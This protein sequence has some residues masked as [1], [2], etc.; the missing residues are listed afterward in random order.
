[1]ICDEKKSRNGDRGLVDDESKSLFYFVLENV[2]VYY[3]EMLVLIYHSAS[4]VM[5]FHLL[6]SCFGYASFFFS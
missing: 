1:M 5:V 2:D 3:L 6:I 4:L